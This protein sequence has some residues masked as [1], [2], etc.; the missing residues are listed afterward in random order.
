VSK[1]YGFKG[2]WDKEI[3]AFVFVSK[4]ER[5]RYQV[6]TY[7]GVRNGWR[8]ADDPTDDRPLILRGACRCR[9]CREYGGEVWHDETE[10]MTYHAAIESNPKREDEGPMA[11]AQRIAAVVAGKYSRAV[12]GMPHV[13]MS[14]RERDAQLSKLRGQA[15]EWDGKL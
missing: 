9:G 7:G 3:N 5:D 12:Q 8:E 14:R 10:R 15:A 11:Y 4:E 1:Y 6:A 2:S 13:R